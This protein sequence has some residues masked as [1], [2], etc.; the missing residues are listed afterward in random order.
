[1]R[2]SALDAI[3]ITNQQNLHF[4]TLFLFCEIL[5]FDLFF[6]HHKRVKEPVKESTRLVVR[7]NLRSITY[8]FPE[9]VNPRSG[10][11]M[12]SDGRELCSPVN[13]LRIMPSELAF[14]DRSSA[15]RITYAGKPTFRA[16]LPTLPD[17][18]SLMSFIVITP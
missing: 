4:Q 5:S 3:W 2:K 15:L 12:H 8:I 10:I 9:Q 1:M 6:Y 16:P 18:V 17:F 14:A 11:N 7:C 13:L